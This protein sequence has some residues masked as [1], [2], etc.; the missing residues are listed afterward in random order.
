MGGFNRRL[1]GYSIKQVD[2]RI[3]ALNK[4]VEYYQGRI[5]IL[6]EDISQKDTLIEE[7][8]IQLDAATERV[9]VMEATQ[10]EIARMALKEAATL[11]NKAKHNANLILTESLLY[12][13]SLSDEMDDFKH[14]TK[15]FRTAVVE[16]SKDL[17]DTIDNS[18]VF[19]ILNEDKKD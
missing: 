2:Q 12:V 17:L 1:F 5:D 19:T 10:E 4:Q 7:M 6:E 16:M 8:T 13:R 15:K 14:K 3:A 11:I 18:E 9:E